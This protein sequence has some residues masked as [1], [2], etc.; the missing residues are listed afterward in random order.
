MVVTLLGWPVPCGSDCCRHRNKESLTLSFFAVRDFIFSQS[1]DLS[2]FLLL[3]HHSCGL[4]DLLLMLTPVL[5]ASFPRK[6]SC[7]PSC[8]QSRDRCIL[9]NDTS[10]GK[11]IAINPNTLQLVS[12][13]RS[14]DGSDQGFNAPAVIWIAV[15]LPRKSAFLIFL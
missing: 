8:L 1:L 13:G 5:A 6:S 15:I 9:R 2:S 14:T 3:P 7:T 4:S 11:L 12:Q 10:A